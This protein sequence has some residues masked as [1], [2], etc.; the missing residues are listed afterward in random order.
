MIRTG[1]STQFVGHSSGIHAG[2]CNQTLLI[3]WS[4]CTQSCISM[5]VP[6]QIHVLCCTTPGWSHS[7]SEGLLHIQLASAGLQE[8][9][10][11]C[12]DMSNVLRGSNTKRQN[13]LR[14]AGQRHEPL[15]HLSCAASEA[16]ASTE[17]TSSQE[18]KCKYNK[19]S[20]GQLDISSG[21]C[22]TALEKS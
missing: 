5:D 15:E 18:L 8:S 22:N 12:I 16:A 21:R 2:R 6:L 19:S 13:L 9:G 3:P 11:S 4:G 20:W 1:S 10:A 7:F 17:K 14:V